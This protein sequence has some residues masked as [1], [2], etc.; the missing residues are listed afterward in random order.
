MVEDGT[1]SAWKL[2][3]GKTPEGERGEELQVPRTIM[4]AKG[5]GER[6]AGV[7]KTDRSPLSPNLYPMGTT[8]NQQV[9]KYD[10][11]KL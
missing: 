3:A 8:V 11:P 1:P 10:N 5:E 4:E 6:V 9:E 7:R 2:L